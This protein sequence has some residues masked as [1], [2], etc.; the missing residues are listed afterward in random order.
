MPPVPLT[1]VPAGGNFLPLTNF[2]LVQ[3]TLSPAIVNAN[4]SAE[5]IFA[6]PGIPAGAA[7]AAVTKP[8]AQA[9]LGIVGCR[10]S[11]AGNIGITFMND[12]AAGITPTASEIY[13]FLVA[14]VT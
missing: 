8:T 3:A 12:T 13:T 11:S 4:T 6:V 14:T 2:L 1:G 7:V 10:V 9:G 5:Q